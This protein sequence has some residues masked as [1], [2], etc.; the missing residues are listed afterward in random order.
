[1]T[2][3]V[4]VMAGPNG[5]G[6]TTFA[7]EF[8]PNYAHCPTFVNAD[9][10]AAKAF[11]A[12]TRK[13][14]DCGWKIAAGRDRNTGRTTCGFWIRD[15]TGR[16]GASDLIRDLKRRG[17][18]VHSFFLWLPSVELAISR[19]KERVLRGGHDIPI[20]VIRR[21]F[22]RS[23]RNFW[24]YYRPAADEWTLFDSEHRPVVVASQ[25][26]SVIQIAEL[27]VYNVIVGSI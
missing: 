1:M 6:K 19:V 13:R 26:R 4:Y 10:I 8:L 2:S 23:F 27:T 12:R 3:H 11:S 7:R 24:N 17:Y 16:A 21:R 5:A 22:E 18:E 9:L 25:A 20:G 14:C 15:D